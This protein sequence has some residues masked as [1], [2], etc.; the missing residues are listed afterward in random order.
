[1]PTAVVGDERIKI[2]GPG[3]HVTSAHVENCIGVDRP[4]GCEAAAVVKAGIL[5]FK[6]QIGLRRQSAACVDVVER[7]RDVPAS[8]RADV[9]K[10]TAANGNV[11]STHIGCDI[12]IDH[13]APAT[14]VSVSDSKGRIALGAKS[15]ANAERQRR[16]R[17]DR[18]AVAVIDKSGNRICRKIPTGSA[19]DIGSATDL[20]T[21]I[22]QDLE[23]C[24]ACNFNT[25]GRYVYRSTP[26][27][28]STGRACNVAFVQNLKGRSASN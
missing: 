19:R 8:V 9:S 15:A 20:A 25:G 13:S 3:G 10:Q 28:C 5:D 12:A 4:T 6:I 11:G 7:A 27:D 17:T 18:A 14:I 24:V 22:I 21:V 16:P 2:V 26:A 23:G 1:M